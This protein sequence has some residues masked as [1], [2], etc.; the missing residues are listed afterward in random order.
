MRVLISEIQSEFFNANQMLISIGE[1]GLEGR[2]QH[3][4]A[5]EQLHN[6]K[7][8]QSNWG[9]WYELEFP[10]EEAFTWFLLRWA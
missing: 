1:F 5:F 10:S 7:V 3:K 8:T 9:N 4:D 6:V 2:K